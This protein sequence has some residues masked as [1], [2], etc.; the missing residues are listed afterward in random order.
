MLDIARDGT[1]QSDWHFL[2]RQGAGFEADGVAGNWRLRPRP[3]LGDAARRVPAAGYGAT[4]FNETAGWAA[5]AAENWT[6]TAQGTAIGLFNTPI[7]SN[8]DR[9]DIA[10]LPNG[11]VGID[12]SST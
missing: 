10:I 3:Q 6:D 7:G 5:F 8:E 1:C 12:R 4:G 11:N 2:R 9:L